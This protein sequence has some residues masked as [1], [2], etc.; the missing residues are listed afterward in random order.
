[1]TSIVPPNPGVVHGQLVTPDG[2][3]AA[4]GPKAELIVQPQSTALAAP[5]PASLMEAANIPEYMRGAPTGTEDMRE[6]VRPPF[7][8][9]VQAMSP[10]EVKKAHGESACYAS[11]SN[12]L[13]LPAWKDGEPLPVVRFVPVFMYR[14]Y[15]E[16][17]PRA[18]KDMVRSRS[19]DPNS[20][21][22]AKCRSFEKGVRSYP[23]PEMPADPR[24]VVKCQEHLN[25]VVML[26]GH[27]LTM[28]ML[29]SFSAGKHKDG[30]NFINL[31][32]MRQA[33]MYGLMFD[34]SIGQRKN[35][36]NDQYY[37]FDIQSTITEDGRTAFVD[38]EW[39][40][41]LK[42]QHLEMKTAFESQ[43]LQAVYEPEE[44]SAAP[45][46]NEG[47]PKF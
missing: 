39:F 2:S 34:M 20:A 8:S 3:V 19:I 7:I 13:I 17:N 45:V 18:H 14:E 11:G 12:A 9:I 4:S 22:A 32:T 43:T 41:Y 26:L 15:I 37:S 23:C 24:N 21:L 44:A 10:S 27:E 6:Y 35:D 33:P 42:G 40:D 36:N 46:V 5:M 25:F 38:K 47:T 28:P 1:M 29:L 30:R 16:W 31:I